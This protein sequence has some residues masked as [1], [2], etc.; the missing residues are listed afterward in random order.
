MA[1][2]IASARLGPGARRLVRRLREQGI[3]D[4]RVLE[5]IATVPRHALVDEALAHRAY[6]DVALPIG[7]GQTI[8]APGTVAVMTAAL[9]LEGRE[10]V[11]EVGTGSGYQAAVLAQLSASV[12]SIERVPVLADRA[13]SALDRMGVTRVVVQLGD[14]TRGWPAAA[15]FD[16]VIVTA[17]GPQVPTPLLAQLAPGGRLVGPFGPRSAQRLVRIRRG[18]DGS[19]SREELGPCRFVDLLGD[20]GWAA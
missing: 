8:S 17:G 1:G 12:V 14:G 18:A 13:R 19:L 4:A 2:G 7:H 5:A 6:E 20:H 3:R 15:P 10:R 9:E 16:A 11:L